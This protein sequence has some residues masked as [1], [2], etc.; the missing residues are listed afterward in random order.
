MKEIRVNYLK[1]TNFKGVKYFDLPVNGEDVR[2][3]GDNA[4][5]K[6]TL[7]D[8]FLWLLFDKDSQNK[9]DFGIKTLEQGKEKHMLD[10][11]V[12]CGL[13]VDNQPMVLR[14]VF[15]EKWTQKRGSSASEFTGHETNYFIDETPLKKSEFNKRIETIVEEE[16]F[17]LLTSPSYFNEQV[18]WQ[19]RRK[20]VL[21]ISGEVEDDEVFQS[22]DDL[23]G[24]KLILKGKNL[25]DFKK[26]ISSQRKKINEEL[27]RIP[28]RV[29][30]LELSI[31]EGEADLPAL[32]AKANELDQQ[33]EELQG[34]ISSIKNGKAVLTKEG[35]LQKI[36]M[37][38]S[39][40]KR[41]FENDSKEELYR[42]K[43]KLQE[44]QSNLQLMTSR[45]NEKTRDISY[46]VE[47]IERIEK[48][49]I[50]L[51]AKWS[52]INK[53]QPNHNAECACPTCGQELPEEQVKAAE[54]KALAQFNLRKSGE[55]K[56]LQEDGGRGVAE[57]KRI[58]EEN[59]RHQSELDELE[60]AIAA[61]EKAIAKIKA[62]FATAES[63]VQ[64]VTK[65]PKFTELQDEAAHI[66]SDIGELKYKADEAAEDIQAEIAQLKVKRDAVNEEVAVYAN[67]GPLKA[68]IQEYMDQEEALAAEFEKLEHHLF[69]V[70][71]FTRA[72]VKIMEDKINSK[73]KYAR[74]KLFENQINGGLQEV[75]ETTF[76]G[77]PY[78][79]G[80]NN[81]ARIN[82]G[83]DIINTLSEFHGIKA[84][85][86]IDNAEA[87][88]KLID[89]DSQLIS[90]V[91]SEADKKLRVENNKLEEAI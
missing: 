41:E 68:R 44:E 84:P 58:E 87:V 76:E 81:A 83:L 91:V 6:T 31:P 26:T 86:F 59:N 29:N 67:V 25:E 9:K 63:S 77:V 39:N 28:I 27:D 20:I 30:E 88:T 69:L 46:N 74:F 8:A 51:R 47:R 4:T 21:S 60:T 17:K 34:Q 85:I 32:K 56:K 16:I 5:G 72:K 90:L 82:V 65:S 70:D 10:H 54:E 89:T 36:E 80:L 43:A 38:I 61:K 40:F 33:I 2:V 55:L 50:E 24:L 64:D 45:K 19:D 23:K 53:Q 73:F 15:R 1:L 12:E 42:L 62:D 13:S 7:F 35:E 18:K 57:K 78:G 49:L 79:S 22:Q 48:S 11:E 71:E 3:Y 14:K 52:E 75:C 37:E 66:R